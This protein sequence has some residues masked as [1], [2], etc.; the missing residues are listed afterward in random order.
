MEGFGRREPSGGAAR[1]KIM[2]FVHS[3]TVDNEAHLATGWNDAPLSEKGRRQALELRDLV[4]ERFDIVISSDLSRALETA[5]IAF[6]PLPVETD[7]RL[8]EINYGELNGCLSGLV[9]RNLMQY[10]VV[11]FPGGESY[12]DV[13]ERMCDF[14]RDMKHNYDGKSVA[15]VAHQ[16][17]QLALDV[18]L[19][20][21]SWEQAF[22]DDWRSSGTWRPGWV[23]ELP[24]GF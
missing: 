4:T 22:H 16:A 23:F 8:R 21:K 13:K 18:L 14:L 15:L 20:E 6:A 12:D 3:T 17:P 11:P 19:N 10:V 24:D 1:M 9:K 2:Y 5:T 7:P